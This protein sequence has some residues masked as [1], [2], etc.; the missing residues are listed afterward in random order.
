M[1]SGAHDPKDEPFFVDQIKRSTN[2]LLLLV[3]DILY[4]SRLDAN[5]EEF[6]K[7]EVDF[8]LAFEEV[9][10][11]GMETIKPGVQS[12]I[13]QPYSSIVVDIDLNHVSMII[14]RLCA[15]SCQSTTHGSITAG[16]EYRRGELT[17]TIENTGTGVSAEDMEHIFE[18]FSRNAKGDMIGSGLDLPIVRLLTEQMGGSIDIQSDYGKGTSIWVSIPCKAS[19]IQKKRE[20]ITEE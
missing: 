6:T 20:F 16:Y 2:D 3:N 19:T 12:V 8:A 17:I 1:F 18:N 13:N 4:L 7:E 10:R 9:C 15:L 11:S 14:R 5:M